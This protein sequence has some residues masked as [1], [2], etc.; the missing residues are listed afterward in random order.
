MTLMSYL[1]SQSQ[2]PPLRNWGS[3]HLVRRE[4]FDPVLHTQPLLSAYCVPGIT[5]VRVCVPEGGA[6]VTLL[7]PPPSFFSVI[8][9]TVRSCKGRANA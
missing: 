6:A 8:H 1:L 9:R 3:S 4:Q 5:V 7:F 2:S